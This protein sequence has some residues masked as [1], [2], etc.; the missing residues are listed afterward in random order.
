MTD[1]ITIRRP[2]DFHH[3]CRDG[4]STASVLK[5]AVP[6][7][8]RCLMMPNL[9]PPVTTTEMALDYKKR[10]IASMPPNSHSSFQPLM[11]LYLTDKTN[12]EEIRKA[13]ALKN[14]DGSPTIVGCKY[15]PAGATTNSDFG[16]SDVTN[17]YPVLEAMQEVGMMLCIHSE[18]THAV[19]FLI[20]GAAMIVCLFD[21]PALHAIPPI[22]ARSGYF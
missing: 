17:L 6:R 14:D 13:S 8:A 11:T 22:F 19:C 15:Y 4:P 16:V 12:P 5:H 10:I 9:N 7:F 20:F 21:C 1:K 3:H 18:V 2:D